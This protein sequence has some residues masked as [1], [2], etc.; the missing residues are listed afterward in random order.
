MLPFDAGFF[1]PL[2]IVW[3]LM[4]WILGGV[5]FSIFALIRVHRIRRARFGCLFTFAAAGLA[6]I[7]AWGGTTIARGS[8]LACE[9][10]PTNSVII[11]VEEW[12]QEFACGIIPLTL[13]FVIGFT[14]LLL[15]GF[16]FLSL[17]RGTE[18]A[19][20]EDGKRGESS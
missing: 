20:I 12:I 4:Y 7:A 18:K 14:L 11:A 19:W 3:F 10:Q 15:L 8:L 2:L 17:S 13:S 5:F 6:V 1:V 9:M 16:I